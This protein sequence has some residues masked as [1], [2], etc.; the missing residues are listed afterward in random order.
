MTRRETSS[1]LTKKIKKISSFMSGASL[2]SLHRLRPIVFFFI[3]NDPTG[4]KQVT[5]NFIFFI[6]Y[7]SFVFFLL[8][9]EQRGWMSRTAEWQR[10]AGQR[11]KD[12]FEGKRRR[13]SRDGF[14]NDEREGEAGRRSK[15]GF[16]DC[17][18]RQ[19]KL[20]GKKNEEKFGFRRR[21]QSHERE[22]VE[23]G[24]LERTASFRG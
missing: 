8:A 11:S 13:K 23:T 1:N 21:F 10:G 4:S 20:G 6:S 7:F 15:D 19:G 9:E 17:Y 16:K 24:K 5:V 14:V 18:E 12:E 2:A 22:R 3:L